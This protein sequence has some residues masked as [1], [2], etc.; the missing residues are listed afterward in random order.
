M[1]AT[2]RPLSTL[3]PP[4]SHFD[5]WLRAIPGLRV[6]T[7]VPLFRHHQRMTIDPPP[8]VGHISL[9][10]SEVFAKGDVGKQ[11]ISITEW[12]HPINYFVG[13]N[14]SGKSRTATLIASRLGGRMLST[15]R[16]AGI[17]TFN[18]YGWTS[19]PTTETHKGI[20][21]GN[22]E[23]S[24]AHN[25][26][27]INGIAIDEM[28]A[29]K[30][31]PAVSL[32]V[33]AFVRRA[34]GREI[35]LRE[36]SGFLDPFIRI[37][38]VEYSLL[39]EEGHG[40]RELI[41][42]LSAV[43]RSD[44]TFLVVDEPELHLHPSLVRLWITE[45][46][47]ECK[48]T[49]RRAIVVTHEPSLLKPTSASDLGAIWYFALGH[50][51]LPVADH[52]LSDQADRVTSSLQRNPQLVSELVF[53]PRPVLVEG[54]DDL[55]AL[56]TAL[57][58]TQPPEIVAQ[59]QLVDCGGSGGVALWLE[60]AKKMGLDVRAVADLD[61][62]FSSEVQRV[63]D[64][65]SSVTERYRSDMAVEPPQTS[66][67]LRPLYEPMDAAGVPSDP[68]SRSEWLATVR[69]D[70]GWGARRDQLLRI[71]REAGLWLHQQGTLEQVLGTSGKGRERAQ[72]AAKVPGPIDE[73][74]EWAAYELDPLG[75]VETLLGLA[76]E[77]IA[78]SIMEVLRLNPSVR[79]TSPVGSAADAR[80]VEVEPLDEGRYRI[81][82]KEP[83][84]F[85]GYW[86]DFS[87]DT[88]SN[89]LRLS[90]PT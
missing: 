29:L 47:R 30:E 89:A 63:M 78:H 84:E 14:G 39:R 55:S 66:K 10:Q 1:T 19:V 31:E 59:T 77:R 37:D 50:P 76:V 26:S 61:A 49:G 33:A 80:L 43:Y 23:R 12:L 81:T 44:W 71:W 2:C 62:C 67:V 54:I 85:I 16:L 74:A 68:K 56:S 25:F 69:A 6:L 83:K 82:V 70:T 88:P 8:L 22:A 15:D 64:A 11:Q 24:Q 32:R 9:N 65:S 28:Y 40:L 4:P 42:L 7:K 53:A 5:R 52:V 3:Q 73:V 51:V 72:A 20:P 57:M 86:L 21:L 35:E 87:R 79:L 58:R 48:G 41:I 90:P 75:D 13:R 17:M 60:I 45:L 18:S 38:N 27:Q 46:E 34:L 36:Q